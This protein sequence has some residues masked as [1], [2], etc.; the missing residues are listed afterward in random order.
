M[1]VG[2]NKE[3]NIELN[4]FFPIL[5]DD[6]STI[7]YYI[8]RETSTKYTIQFGVGSYYYNDSIIAIAILDETDVRGD[9]FSGGYVKNQDVVDGET[10]FLPFDDTAS[11]TSYF[12]ISDNQIEIQHI[13]MDS[14]QNVILHNYA[15]I[16]IKK[17]GLSG[18]DR[19]LKYFKCDIEISYE[20]EETEFQTGKVIKET[21]KNVYFEEIKL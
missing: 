20:R 5:T 1:F 7:N 11:Y 12:N 3:D 2:C 17:S 14:N 13:V 15:I 21:V 8:S 18:R 4:Q 10:I 9:Y 19:G 6:I 16:T